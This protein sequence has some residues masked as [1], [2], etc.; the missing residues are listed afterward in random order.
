MAWLRLRP[1]P[2]SPSR[3][4]GAADFGPRPFLLRGRVYEHFREA[5]RFRACPGPPRANPKRHLQLGARPRPALVSLEIGPTSEGR[6]FNVRELGFPFSSYLAGAWRAGDVLGGASSWL[7][8]LETR[9]QSLGVMEFHCSGFTP[10]DIS[11]HDLVVCV[12]VCGQHLYRFVF[13]NPYFLDIL[14]SISFAL[15]FQIRKCNL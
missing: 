10:P 15:L 6:V 12:C 2:F 11:R 4:A 3:T 14:S 13:V 8:F 7:W 9:A 1:L 5:P